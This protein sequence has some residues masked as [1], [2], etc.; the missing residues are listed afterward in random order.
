MQVNTKGRPG[1]FGHDDPSM[2]MRIDDAI[3]RIRGETGGREDKKRIGREG[4]N[5]RIREREE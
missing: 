4:Y 1:W 2:S 5:N 3:D